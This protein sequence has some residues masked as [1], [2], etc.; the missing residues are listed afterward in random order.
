MGASLEVELKFR[1]ESQAPLDTLAMLQ[2]LGPA[3]LGQAI[4]VDEWDR[5]LDTADRRLS[6]ALWA[7]RLRETRTSTVVS[8]KGPPDDQTMGALHRRPE[9][10]GP[11]GDD[12]DTD[13]WPPSDARDF[14]LHLSGGAPLEVR[15]A[16][17]QLRTQ[18]PASNDDKPIATLTLDRVQVIRDGMEHGRLFVVELELTAGAVKSGLDPAPLVAALT[19]IPDLIAEPHTKLERALALLPAHAP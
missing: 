12:L 15:L 11:A 14:L 16:L 19:A 10:E 18:R 6:K 4:V 1:A 8:L 5:Y 9:I 13:D 17:R 3:S 7:C 2:R